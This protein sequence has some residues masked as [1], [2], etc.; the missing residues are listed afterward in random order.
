MT[1][2]S[3]GLLPEKSREPSAFLHRPLPVDRPGEALGKPIAR[4]E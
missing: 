1:G 2:E 3:G 4:S